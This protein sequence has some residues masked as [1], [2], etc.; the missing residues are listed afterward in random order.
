MPT[1][2]VRLKNQKITETDQCVQI[3]YGDKL[4]MCG[5]I[6]AR[7]GALVTPAQAPG[8]PHEECP[9]NLMSLKAEQ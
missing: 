1:L 9:M 2:Q 8:M 4:T 3:Q 7:S 5:E 6:L